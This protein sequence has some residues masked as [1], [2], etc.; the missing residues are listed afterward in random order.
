MRFNLRCG[1]KALTHIWNKH[2]ITLDEIYLAANDRKNV[3]VRIKGMTYKVTGMSRDRII[4]LIVKRTD[5]EYHLK[6]ARPSSE[7]EKRLYKE[8]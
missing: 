1:R 4:T 6:T 7:K 2:S 8:R 3:F 5:T